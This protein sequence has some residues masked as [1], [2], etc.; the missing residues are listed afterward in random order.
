M[1]LRMIKRA[2]FAAA[3][4]PL[5]S[6]IA[7]VHSV[8]P[9]PLPEGEISL[10]LHTR[11]PMFDLPATRATNEGLPELPLPWVLVFA[12]RDEN[13]TFVE[14]QK[15]VDRDGVA[16]VTLQSQLKPCRL[17]IIANVE[18]LDTSDLTRTTK[19]F[20][21]CDDLLTPLLASS[22][23]AFPY[24]DGY[25]PMS[26]IHQ[27]ETI[28]SSTKLGEVGAE[29]P[30]T[31]SVAKITV[32][33]TAT[34]FTLESA[35]VAN[36]PRQGA[37]HNLGSS[38]RD[39]SAALT[40]YAMPAVTT[41]I[42]LYEAS[43][44]EKTSVIVKGVYDGLTGYYKLTLREE[45]GGAS[46]AVLRNHIYKVN[47]TEV[48]RP[49]FRT[50]TE[51]VD[52]AYPSNESIVW[53]VEVT[54]GHA[55]DVVD[56]GEYYLGVS[57]SEYILY[58]DGEQP[59]RLAFVAT[60]NAA[61]N[62]T[63]SATAGGDGLSA[64]FSSGSEGGVRIY[65]VTVGMTEE[66][67]ADTEGSVTVRVGNLAK[68]VKVS[69]R[70]A[71]AGARPY[72]EFNDTHYVAAHIDSESDWLRLSTDKEDT[73]DLRSINQET[74]SIYIHPDANYGDGSSPREAVVYL[75]R[76]DNNPTLGRVR[77]EMVQKVATVEWP[78]GNNLN[79]GSSTMSFKGTPVMMAAPYVGTFHRHDEMGER[80]LRIPTI[81]G[82]V[83]TKVMK[84]SVETT[85]NVPA[86]TPLYNGGE[87]RAEVVDGK[88]IALDDNFP[89]NWPTGTA[90]TTPAAVT[91][92]T[93]WVEAATSK[94]D[95][96]EIRFRLGLTG[97][98]GATETRYGRVM[99]SYAD[100]E[101]LYFIYVRQGEEPDYLVSPSVRSETQGNV[102]FSP[103]NL[104][105]TGVNLKTGSYWFTVQ[106]EAPNV[107]SGAVGGFVDYPTMAGGQF[108]F[109]PPAAHTWDGQTRDF[110][111]R[112]FSPTSYSDP[113]IT[114]TNTADAPAFPY[115]SEEYGNQNTAFESATMETCPVGF[116]RPTAGN[117][118]AS[119]PNTNEFRNSLF[120][121]EGTI[122]DGNGQN[123]ENS[124]WGYYADGYFDRREL[125]T[126]Q[127]S[128][129]NTVPY[130]AVATSSG[131]GNNTWD[132]AYIG[133]L[134]F[135]EK[136]GRHASIFF[137][138]AGQRH[139]DGF[140]NFVGYGYYQSSNGHNQL[141]TEGNVS[142]YTGYMMGFTGTAPFH[143]TVH[144]SRY[145]Y[146]R[147]MAVSLRCVVC[148]DVTADN[149]TLTA[150]WDSSVNPGRYV[151]TATTPPSATVTKYYWEYQRTRP[152][153]SVTEWISFPSGTW[154]TTTETNYS[155]I[156][157]NPN[158]N[159]DQN[160]GPGEY[161]FRVKIDYSQ[162]SRGSQ[163][164]NWV[165]TTESYHAN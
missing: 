62:Y 139:H 95:H 147:A 66:F 59:N 154:A 70:P 119:G 129:Y 31:R 127:A 158:N 33:S 26:G 105:A 165:E 141:V 114:A 30:L 134:F 34:G 28:G 115:W 121:K 96:D 103:Y 64:A 56:N 89:V 86:L 40:R 44:N 107:A 76:H 68:T 112:A 60:T 57:N 67:T 117:N 16:S 120:T 49:G 14:A 125:A 9:D 13:A 137:P 135:N 74:G 82:T 113:R 80:L 118:P 106:L 48:R 93:Q 151:V 50:V 144:A 159:T 98:I 41:P 104:T 24:T 79:N 88:F 22:D 149:M 20:E 37:Y 2:V 84:A 36:A 52:S 142:F 21:A 157:P 152:D 3:L 73:G 27:V 163:Q 140:L 143:G 11:A 153:G 99:V 155:R 69:R 111:R 10:E 75:S 65:N 42:Y 130:G 138:G 146:S 145:N 46:L 101:K 39:N 8:D 91:G 162:C 160:L 161:K 123:G 94:D 156:T 1:N 116:R 150:R 54:D 124:V 85:F 25:L 131:T 17:L 4:L 122:P 90:G 71:V 6:C 97:T 78:I 108:Q 55:H 7:D 19:L 35:T 29:I 15:A 77:V 133:R 45:W 51:A 38:P 47:I 136:D 87:W 5:A 126:Q 148:S 18:S 83:T 164:S 128:A 32:N 110:R 43:A 102:R 81:H 72:L 58:A 109:A 61:S 23:A 100:H 92:G 132:V 12:G 53:S 63:F